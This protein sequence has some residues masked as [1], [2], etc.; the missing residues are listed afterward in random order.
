MRRGNSF[1]FWNILALLLI[2]FVY[3]FGDFFSNYPLDIRHIEKAL[4]YVVWDYL[5]Y[6]IVGTL[7]VSFL[8]ALLLRKRRGLKIAHLQTFFV[9][10]SGVLVYLVG[11]VGYLFVSNVIEVSEMRDE[12][13]KQA[14]EDIRNDNVTFRYAGLEVEL[15]S[16]SV[17]SK[18]DSICRIF[19]VSYYNTGCMINDNDIVA[20][21][22]YDELVQPYLDKRNG[23]DWEERMNQQIEEIIEVLH[24]K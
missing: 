19:G 22:T 21:E 9:L 17:T 18:I 13:R 7:L 12:Y 20:Q 24:S 14:N 23:V 11:M 8:L 10:N 15:H 1:I 5:V 16:S 6:L 4:E 3:T 2:V